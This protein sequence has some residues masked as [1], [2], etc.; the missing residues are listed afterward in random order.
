VLV[1]DWSTSPPQASVKVGVRF[2]V[3]A[4]VIQEQPYQCN[5]GAMSN[6]F[7]WAATDSSV[8]VFEG[9]TPSA[10]PH[11]GSARRSARPPGGRARRVRPPRAR[12]LPDG[13]NRS[14]LVIATAL[15]YLGMT[16]EEAVGHLR[17]CRPGALFNENFAAHV[18]GLPARRIRV[19]IL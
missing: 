14:V 5:Q 1:P 13:F 2:S 17:E 15:T 9:K 3:S 8:L 11:R 16:G 18:A 10:R 7:T 4:V 6:D 19:E 12:P